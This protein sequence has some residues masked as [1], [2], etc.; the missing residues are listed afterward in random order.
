MATYQFLQPQRVP[1]CVTIPRTGIP[2]L[3]LTAWHRVCIALQTAGKIAPALLLHRSVAVRAAAVE[4]VAAAAA[5]LSAADVFVELLPR[6][7]PALEGSEYGANV[8]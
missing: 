3:Y 7:Q 6:V 1:V 5:R 2:R 4:F 8:S